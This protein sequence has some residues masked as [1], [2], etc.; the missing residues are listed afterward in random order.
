GGGGGMKLLIR[1]IIEA[2]GGKLLAGAGTGQAE[3]VSTDTRT[4]RRGEL[5]FALKGP[6]F[7]GHGFVGEAAK[8]GASGA[9]AAAVVEEGMRDVLVKDLPT[10]FNLIAV[11]DTLTALGD[12]A[13]FVRRSRPVPVVAISGST[14]KTTVKE[15]LASIL[16]TTKSVLKTEG[17]MNNLVGLPLTLFG[18][19]DVQE[20]VVVELGISEPGEMER[21]A[22][23]CGAD[24]AVVTN[25]GRG[26]LE[27]LGSLDGVAEEKGYLFRSLGPRGTGVVNADDPRVM[28]I[29]DRAGLKGDRMI[30]FGLAGFA[31]VRIKCF[32]RNGANVANTIDTVYEI[33]GED[34]EVRLNSPWSCN[35]YNGA[36]A[37]AA[38]LSL[39]VRVDEIREGLTSYLPMP[40]RM[41]VL[42]L[43]GL[44][45]FDDT[46][47]ANPESVT[48]ALK[49]LS[50]VG[51]GLKVAVLGD[52]LE[53]GKVSSE[54]HHEIGQLSAELGLDVLLCVGEWA[55]AI[56]EGAR[57]GGME[58]E[59]I[60][61]FDDNRGA[62]EMLRSSLGKGDTVLIKGS[63]AVRMEELVEG[64]K[65][66]RLGKA[67]RSNGL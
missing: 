45:V 24:V 21:L 7:D 5:F 46:Y 56:S 49:T 35:V 41:E 52:M 9:V 53:L 31:E 27:G 43:D 15:M 51:T 63:R 23:I 18:L 47:N 37:A 36:A 12:L 3:G 33:R 54:A 32:S 62:L 29:A 34:V 64:L 60:H 14:G 40:G 28:K 55:A 42:D 39:G 19:S 67:A 6:N 20:V 58:K 1:D 17:N 10:S 16:S 61:C 22:E 11:K 65:E 25:V 26:H 8:R 2:T 44:T 48:A 30:T 57:D 59:N 13:G 66:E 38:A 4:V 50:S